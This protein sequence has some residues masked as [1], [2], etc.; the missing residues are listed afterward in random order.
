MGA[1]KGISDLHVGEDVNPSSPLEEQMKE[2]EEREPE[3]FSKISWG[4]GTR[5]LNT[6]SASN[7]GSFPVPAPAPAPASVPVSAPA[8]APAPA[9]EPTKVPPPVPTSGTA[10]APADDTNPAPTPK[11]V[12]TE[13]V[14]EYSFRRMSQLSYA[15]RMAMDQREE[16]ALRKFLASLVIEKAMTVDSS[17]NAAEVRSRRCPL[18]FVH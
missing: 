5:R 1:A 3:Q 18:G 16:T 13:I 6:P 12:E 8:P 2:W 9:P 11:T 7:S 17:F 4:Q 10:S 14:L 15:L